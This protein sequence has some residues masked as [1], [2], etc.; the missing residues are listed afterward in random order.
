MTARDF[1]ILLPLALASSCASFSGDAFLIRNVDASIKA[2]AVA[3]QGVAAYEEQLE[4]AGDYTKVEEIRRYFEV[5][6]D[7]DPANAKAEEYLAKVDG[8]SKKFVGSRLAAAQKILAKSPRE[9]ADNY[10]ILVALQSARAA[11]SSN[12]KVNKLLREQRATKDK[13]SAQYLERSLA[14]AARADPPEAPEG[15]P[16]AKAPSAA[17]RE[18]AFA[19][20]YAYASKAVAVDPD[21]AK[22][23]KAKA[24]AQGE[25]GK[26]FES[27]AAEI[28][29]KI[30]KS[31]FEEAKASFAKL[32]AYDASI[33][34]AFAKDRRELG[35]QLYLAWAKSLESKKD[36]TGAREK[37]DAALAQKR[38][39]EALALRRR[40]VAV[41]TSVAGAADFDAAVADL[42]KLIAKGDL[43]QAQRRLNALD[44]VAKDASRKA[45]LAGRHEKLKAGLGAVYDRGVNAYRE[46]NFKLAIEQLNVVIAI[47][48][49]Y[50]QASDYLEKAKEKQKLVDQ[51]SK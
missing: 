12:D 19:E 24:A 44:R 16:P 3:A 27:R 1:I 11:D 4:A 8:Y 31:R 45:K 51:F 33:G 14:A 22:A 20:S 28:K 39:E 42:D 30:A 10:A 18:A 35:Y 29:A 6:L 49:S 21:N 50:E 26:G 48:P 25:L 2:E 13:L 23:A 37:A 17:A 5:A 15:G 40:V 43:G 46:E 38:G 47:D 34:G 9:E 41:M 7:Y 32:S 36:L